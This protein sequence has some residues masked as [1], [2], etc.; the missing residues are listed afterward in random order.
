M[1]TLKTSEVARDYLRH[2][3]E[4]IPASWWA[5]FNGPSIE[6]LLCELDVDSQVTAPTRA[7]L[8]RKTMC[9]LRSGKTP[10]R[11]RLL[12]IWLTYELGRFSDSVLRLLMRLDL[13]GLNKASRWGVND[14]LLPGLDDDLDEWRLWLDNARGILWP[15]E[16]DL[17]LALSPAQQAFRRAVLGIEV[18]EVMQDGIVWRVP[19]VD[20]SQSEDILRQQF[21]DPLIGDSGAAVGSARNGDQ[22]PSTS[23]DGKQQV[24]VGTPTTDRGRDDN[25]SFLAAV[26]APKQ[27][28]KTA[29]QPGT[30][31]RDQGSSVETQAHL[32]GQQKANESSP[33]RAGRSLADFHR[34][35]SSDT[36]HE[37]SR[38]RPRKSVRHTQLRKPAAEIR[39]PQYQP[40][41]SSLPQVLRGTN[42]LLRSSSS[43]SSDANDWSDWSG[44]GDSTAPSSDKP[45]A[46]P[47]TNIENKV[48]VTSRD[49][50]LKTLGLE[51]LILQTERNI[52]EGWGQ[53]KRL[54]EQEVEAMRWKREV[55]SLRAD[56]ADDREV[57]DMKKRIQAVLDGVRD[58]LGGWGAREEKLIEEK[59]RF[60]NER[61]GLLDG[62]ADGMF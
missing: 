19:G 59:R 61:R 31:M 47:P 52:S 8:R 35:D 51:S 13:V 1:V 32:A 18:A 15:T 58:G 60:V 5:N 24:D 50:R 37:R 56:G 16:E 41:S 29:Q 39:R 25:G 57:A 26:R 10:T 36:D 34:Y 12:A 55:Q 6:K 14:P 11:W 3:L 49:T 44:L 38:K 17:R 46:A 53:Q 27:A 9:Q 23:R 42:R 7:K 21:T 2:A 22:G 45:P 28:S 20:L 30:M 43:E 54:R 48:M 40:Q 62:L 4:G 33:P